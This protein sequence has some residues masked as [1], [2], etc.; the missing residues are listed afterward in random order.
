MVRDLEAASEYQCAEYEG[1]RPEELDDALVEWEALHGEATAIQGFEGD[2]APSGTGTVVP[3]S[4]ELS[5]GQAVESFSFQV[6]VEVDCVAALSG[7]EA[8][9]GSAED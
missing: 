4:V 6:T 9:L 7:G 1:P 8:L 2:P 3:M 5:S